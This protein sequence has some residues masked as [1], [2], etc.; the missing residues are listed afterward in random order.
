MNRA[1][2]SFVLLLCGCSAPSQEV[3]RLAVT[4]STRDSG[5]LDELLPDFEQKYGVRIDVVGVGSGAA[6]RLGESGDVDVVLVHSRRDEARFMAA[7]HGVRREEVMKNSFVILGPQVD[8]AGILGLEPSEALERIADRGA[9]LV[10][11]GDNSGTAKREAEIWAMSAGGSS[12]GSSGWPDHLETGQGM[13]ATIMVANQR[14]AYVLSDR[15]TYLKFKDRIQIV[16]LVTESPV[17]VNPYGVLAVNPRK[18]SSIRGDLAIAFI[19]FLIS[20]EAQEKIGSYRIHGEPLFLPLR[21][22][23]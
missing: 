15:G 18:N 16:P 10:S 3:L 6:L 13:G 19:E 8:P 2:L 5:L 23:N 11:R 21:L 20:R 9:C 4:T 22:E 14:Q 7:G 1:F 17:L 12:V